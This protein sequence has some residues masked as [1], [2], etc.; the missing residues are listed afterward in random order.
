MTAQIT[1]VSQQQEEKISICGVG[2][3]RAVA[4][5]A[6][7]QL[8]NTPFRFAA[9]LDATSPEPYNFSPDRL[10]L[11]LRCLYPEPRCFI[12][13]EGVEE[14]A[15]AAAVEVWNEFV[16]ERKVDNAL[17]INVRLPGEAVGQTELT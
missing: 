17:L 12:A 14:E 16:A 2:R 3:H 10:R 5:F 15:N 4:I 8:E 7:K 13:G 9:I 6:S 11:L 1:M